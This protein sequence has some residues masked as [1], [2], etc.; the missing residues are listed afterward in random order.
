MALKIKYNMEPHNPK[1][2]Y[3][4]GGGNGVD[5]E[6]RVQNLEDNVN[7]LRVDTAEI[8]TAQKL[9]A[10]QTDLVALRTEFHIIFP[11][12]AKKEELMAVRTELKEEINALRTELKEEISAVK[13]EVTVLK[14]EFKAT[15]PHLVTKTW[16][17]GALTLLLLAQ[18]L[19]PMV[20]DN[21]HFNIEKSIPAQ[22]KPLGS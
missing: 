12:L 10:Q 5:L 7:Q 6:R 1:R 17:A 3:G 2:L 18:L 9:A 16:L 15:L 20:K 13:E 11:T 8:K 4:N 21:L 22:V 19:I 14:T